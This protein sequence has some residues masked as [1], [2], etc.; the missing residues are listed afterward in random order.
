MRELYKVE[1][2]LKRRLIALE[3]EIDTSARLDW[4]EKIK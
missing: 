2:L 1:D 3:Q 4:E